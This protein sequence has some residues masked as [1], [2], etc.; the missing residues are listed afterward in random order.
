MQAQHLLTLHVLCTQALTDVVYVC[1]HVVNR[2]CLRR[3]NADIC[4]H[5]VLASAAQPAAA[6]QQA[7]VELAAGVNPVA[8]AVPLAVAGAVLV[9]AAAL[10]ITWA[11]RRKLRLQQAPMKQ[12]AG[13]DVLD[14]HDQPPQDPLG[15]P[16][17]GAGKPVPSAR[18]RGSAVAACGIAS[19]D[20]AMM[21][22][23]RN[24]R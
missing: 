23:G 8:I 9:A 18:T 4:V 3:K 14:L 19:D 21:E 2:S 17:P 13:S 7:P 1:M 24:G 20:S 6:V 22:E 12:C 5:D 15:P 11:R 10:G 16:S